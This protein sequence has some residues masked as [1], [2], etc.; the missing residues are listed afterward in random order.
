MD[1]GESLSV[2]VSYPV[3]AVT[4][5]D[6]CIEQ[7]RRSSARRVRIVL[8][9]RQRLP[10]VGDHIYQRERSGV[11]EASG[12]GC[13]GGRE[14]DGECEGGGGG[15][16]QVVVEHIQDVTHEMHLPKKVSRARL[17]T[18]PPPLNNLQHQVIQPIQHLQVYQY[19]GNVTLCR[20]LSTARTHALA[21]TTLLFPPH[22]RRC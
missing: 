6:L 2:S 10:A 5:R 22:R 20:T 11:Q 8:L 1:G 12:V 14:D 17:N 9:D 16:G 13:A 15:Q 18:P 19:N 4:D 21:H 3:L 7:V